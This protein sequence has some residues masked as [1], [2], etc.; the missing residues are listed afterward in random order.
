[1]N[2]LPYLSIIGACLIFGT[3]GLWIKSLGL[4]SPTIAWFRMMVPVILVVFYMLW[5]RQSIVQTNMK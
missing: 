4:P 5:T 2:Y 3:S 1:M